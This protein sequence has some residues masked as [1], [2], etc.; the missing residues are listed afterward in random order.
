MTPDLSK[1]PDDAFSIW[2]EIPSCEE[3]EIGI[4]REAEPVM[5][6]LLDL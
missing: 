2:P 6:E 1:L 4:F 5:D 3:N